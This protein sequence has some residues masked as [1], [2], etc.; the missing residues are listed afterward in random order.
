[1]CS[2]LTSAISIV[3][4]LNTRQSLRE[5]VFHPS[6]VE[7][8]GVSGTGPLAERCLGEGPSHNPSENA[9]AFELSDMFPQS[10]GKSD[11]NETRSFGLA[12]NSCRRIF[13]ANA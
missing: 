8:F 11:G 4:R 2:E 9:V 6:G 1:M 3:D 7:I 12:L 13:V 5:S 10:Q